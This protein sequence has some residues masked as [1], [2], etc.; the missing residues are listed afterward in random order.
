M[1]RQVQLRWSNHLTTSQYSSPV[2]PTTTTTTA[3]AFTTTTT[4][5]SD[6]IL[7]LNCPQCDRKFTSRIGLVGHFQIHRTETGKPVPGAPTHS[8]DHRLN[9]P[10]CPRAFTHRMGLFGQMRIHD[11][12]IHHNADNTDTPCTPSAPAILTAPATPTTMNDTPS[13][14]TDF[15]C[16]HCACNFNS[17]IG[18]IGH[19]RIHHMEAVE[20]VLHASAWS[21]TCE[22]IAWRLVNQCLGFRHTVDA[23][24]FTALTAPAHLHTAFDIQSTRPPSLPSL[25]PHIYTPHGS[26]RTRAPPRQPAVNHRKVKLN[27]RTLSTPKHRQHP[28]SHLLPEYI[29]VS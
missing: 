7:L 6:G 14:S 8:R 22:S 28:H 2:T 24:A 16:P 26:I 19:L 20:P 5:I 17:R 21:V 29:T 11:S 4:T 15:F 18:L 23:P 10:H 27:Q 25:L 9:C 12:G 13:A 3:F 1:L